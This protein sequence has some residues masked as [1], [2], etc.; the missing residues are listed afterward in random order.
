M[1]K[2]IITG[3]VTM[4]MAG[5]MMIPV[6]ADDIAQDSPN[7]SGTTDVTYT[8]PNKYTISIPK[9]VALDSSSSKTV[10][11]KIEATNVNLAPDNNITIKMTEGVDGNGNVTLKRTGDENTKINAKMTSDKDGDNV[12][13]SNTVFEFIS[14]GEKIM[15]FQSPEETGI[16][17]GTYKGT[18]TFEVSVTTTTSSTN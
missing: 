8:E 9:T 13:T 16:L 3:A 14:N 5:V 6:Q 12:Y 17:A 2:R 18:I 11:T 10:E 15:Y 4:M 1:K 7:K